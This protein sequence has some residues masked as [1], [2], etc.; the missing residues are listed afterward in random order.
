M[1]A[2]HST[3]FG[4]AP[5]CLFLFQESLHTILLNKFE[6]FYHAHVVFCTIAFV[7][8]FQS[9]TGTILAFIT[10]THKSPSQQV[11]VF[12]HKG[13]VLATWQATS[14]VFL[15]KS[16]LIKV[17]LHRQVADTHATIHSARGNEFFLHGFHNN[18]VQDLKRQPP[19]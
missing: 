17:G 18:I 10:E 15:P 3:T 8:V 5:F 16:L 2:Y 14:A 4:A 7:E 9:A 6:V 12:C 11:A 13:A 1:A 19:V